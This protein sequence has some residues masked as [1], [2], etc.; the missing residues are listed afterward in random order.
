MSMH[1]IIFT[2]CHDVLCMVIPCWPASWLD[3]GPA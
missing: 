2:V 1:S 3:Q